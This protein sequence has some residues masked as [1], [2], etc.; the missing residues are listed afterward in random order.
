MIRE[1]EREHAIGV[2]KVTMQASQAS[3]DDGFLPPRFMAWFH[4]RGGTP[5]RHQLEMVERAQ[6]GKNVLLIAP[7]GGGKTLAGF[8]PSLIELAEQPP[9]NDI[10]PRGIHTLDRK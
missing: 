1:T 3:K 9:R 8:L 7:T 4:G 10:T 6:A 5:R 2:N